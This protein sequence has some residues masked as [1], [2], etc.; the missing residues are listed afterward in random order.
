MNKIVYVE[1]EDENYSGNAFFYKVVYDKDNN[2]K[3]ELYEGEFKEK[4]K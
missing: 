2:P 4:K 3:Y 1:N